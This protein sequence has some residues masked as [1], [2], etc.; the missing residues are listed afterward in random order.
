MLAVI[1]SSINN[2]DS[3]IEKLNNEIDARRRTVQKLMECKQ[4]M[5]RFNARYADLIG[6]PD[7]I[8]GAL[9]DEVLLHIISYLDIRGLQRPPCRRFLYLREYFLRHYKYNIDP[10]V[11]NTF[12]QIFKYPIV[13]HNVIND[14]KIKTEDD[15]YFYTC[16]KYGIHNEYVVSG[17]EYM[18]VNSRAKN[19]RRIGIHMTSNTIIIHT[20]YF[21]VEISKDDYR[22]KILSRKTNGPAELHGVFNRIN[23]NCNIPCSKRIVNIFDN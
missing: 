7:G 21:I 6:G 2:I 9:S 12:M 8:F 18:L 3:Q 17:N 10:T 23:R 19:K 11:F 5:E 14:H 13:L 16:S 4:N 22:Y 1:M 15:K 20:Y